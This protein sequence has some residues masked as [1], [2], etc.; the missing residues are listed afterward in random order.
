LVEAVDV[1]VELS[2]REAQSLFGAF[3]DE[4][5]GARQERSLKAH[6]DDCLECRTGWERYAR[7]V[8]GARTL[9]KERAPAGLASM[10]L[11]RVRR[12]RIG[13]R[14]LAMAQASFRIP[15]EMIIPVVIAAAVAALLF[16]M[17]P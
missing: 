13:A 1:Q 16:F 17:A 11:R 9:D 14:S 6:L 4:E 2:H 15:A 3:V 7:V 5:L 12:R 8:N 10:I